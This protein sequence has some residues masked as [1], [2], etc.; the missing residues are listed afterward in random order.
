MRAIRK[1]VKNVRVYQIGS[2]KPFPHWLKKA[3]SEGYIIIEENVGGIVDIATLYRGSRKQCFYEEDYLVKLPE[4][5]IIGVEKE[6][7]YQLYDLQ[8]ARSDAD[9]ILLAI[10]TLSKDIEK[11]ISEK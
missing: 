6:K 3:I 2:R 11:N 10:W 4:G 9:K 1:Q 7:F 8:I 5:P